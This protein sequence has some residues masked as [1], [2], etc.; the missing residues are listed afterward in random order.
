MEY[1]CRECHKTAMRAVDE[2]AALRIGSKVPK[3]WLCDECW[4]KT[5]NGAREKAQ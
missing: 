1:E 3:D 5:K 2:R 4:G